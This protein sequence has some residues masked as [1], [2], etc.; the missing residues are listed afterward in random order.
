MT[1]IESVYDKA[2]SDSLFTSFYEERKKAIP[3]KQ[4]TSPFSTLAKPDLLL[5]AAKTYDS[6]NMYT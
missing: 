2:S 4:K 3:L 1:S 5:N 6:K